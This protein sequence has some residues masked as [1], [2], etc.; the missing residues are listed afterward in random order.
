MRR[1]ILTASDVECGTPV[2]PTGGCV[3][4]PG[5]GGNHVSRGATTLLHVSPRP[6]AKAHPLTADPATALANVARAMSL[7]HVSGIFVERRGACWLVI[8]ERE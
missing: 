2:G 1:K 4:R 8:V 7:R 6:R 3:L 5:H